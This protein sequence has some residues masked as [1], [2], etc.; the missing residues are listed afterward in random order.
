MYRKY[1]EKVR[2]CR[3]EEKYRCL[4]AGDTWKEQIYMLTYIDIEKMYAKKRDWV[5]TQKLAAEMAQK[6]AQ[7]NYLFHFPNFLIMLTNFI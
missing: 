5:K 1:V 6:G 4:E 2:K 7:F 3:D